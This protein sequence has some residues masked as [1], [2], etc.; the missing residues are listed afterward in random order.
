MPDR[1]AGAG[2]QVL[3]PTDAAGIDDV[4]ASTGREMTLA[5][6]RGAGG[7]KGQAAE[8]LGIFRHAFKRRVQRLGIG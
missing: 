2:P 6:L 7:H 5:A 3:R 1:T 8:R 4:L